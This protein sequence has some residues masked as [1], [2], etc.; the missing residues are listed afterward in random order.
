VEPLFQ[1][2]ELDMRHVPVIKDGKRE[3]EF[4]AKLVEGHFRPAGQPQDMVGG[5]PDR[6]EIIY[7]RSRPIKNDIAQP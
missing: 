2:R 5:L 6:R 3:A 7:Q 1:L 4:C